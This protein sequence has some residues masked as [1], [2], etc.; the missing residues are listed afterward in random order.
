MH[1][2]KIAP[3]SD[4]RR[5][6]RQDSGALTYRR[7]KKRA[8]KSVQGR[9]QTQS[10]RKPLFLVFLFC[11]AQFYFMQSSLFQIRELEIDGSEHLS[12]SAIKSKLGLGLHENYWDVNSYSLQENLA[13]LHTLE[14]AEVAV[15]FP[16]RVKVVV[17]ERQASF[18]AAFH[19]NTKTWFSVD[20]DGV[21]L[22]SFKPDKKGLKMV[23]PY[24]LKAGIQ[25]RETDLQLI[26]FFQD[27]LTG[28]L[29][30]RV[31]ALKIRQDGSLAL[32]TVFSK[33]SIWV[34][35]GR[36]ER[37]QYK[38]FLLKELLRQLGHEKAELA[39]VDLRYSTPVVKKRQVKQKPKH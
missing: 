36:P 12:E 2:K 26:R 9:E 10:R 25:I 24:P 13:S 30:N 29:E 28:D 14:R 38:L 19:G 32:K 3:I 23:L 27:Q 37:L 22:E 20:G 15:S 21:V 35:F 6:L 18:F 16:S 1:A 5:Y 11:V 8:R 39:S 7:S 33:R 17:Q 4:S 34:K 31:K